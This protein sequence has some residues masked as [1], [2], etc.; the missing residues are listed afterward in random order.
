[1]GKF[2]TPYHDALASKSLDGVTHPLC[3]VCASF[4]LADARKPFHFPRP[5]R[6]C[7]PTGWGSHHADC[8]PMKAGEEVV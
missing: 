5:A 1:M 8:C 2:A 4:D 7:L 3:D 6:D